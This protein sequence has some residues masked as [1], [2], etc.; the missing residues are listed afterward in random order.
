VKKNNKAAILYAF[1]LILSLTFTSKDANS[2][3][4]EPTIFIDPPS[5][6]DEANTFGN[7]TINVNISYIEGLH[8]WSVNL[9]Y[10]PELLHTNSSLIK[11]GSFLKSGGST[12]FVVSPPIEDYIAVGSSISGYGSAE[13]GSGTL[14]SVTF[15]L[16]RRG[17]T[18]LHLFRTKLT[19]VDGNPITHSSQDGCFRNIESLQIPKAIF[20]YT[21]QAYNVTVNASSSYSPSGTIQNYLWFWGGISDPEKQTSTTN[22]V[23]YHLYPEK[24][25][26]EHENATVRL[27]VTDSNDVTAN[28][29][30]AMITFGIAIHDVTILSVQASPKNVI[31]NYSTTVSV[32]VSNKGNQLENTTLTVSYNS[33]FF[34]FQNITA[35][36]W[37]TLHTDQI[38]A[39]AGLENRTITYFWNTTG[40]PLGFYA[41]KAEASPVQGEENTANNILIGS[42]RIVTVLHTPVPIFDFNPTK[43][44]ANRE[45]TFN[46]SMSYDID[47]VIISYAWNFGDSS[48]TTTT[49]PSTTHI[50][51]KAGTF[52]VTL[53]VT[54]DNIISKNTT[55]SI[56]IQKLATTTTISTA[57]TTIRVDST[58]A[59]NGKVAGAESPV[60]V[61]ILQ[62]TYGKGVW[63]TLT[64]L[65][66]DPSGIFSY[67]HS[68]H[69]AGAYQLKAECNSDDVYQAST[70]NTILITAKFNSTIAIHADKTH[71]P[72]GE[73]TALTGTINPT[74]YGAIAT[75][76]Y[77]L[78]NG[79][80]NLIAHT[81]TNENGNYMFNWRPNQAGTY[82]LRAK[83]NGTPQAFGSQSTTTTVTVTQT[84]STP[85][86]YIIY[87]AAIIALIATA[88]ILTWTRKHKTSPSP[89]NK[90]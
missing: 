86:T 7:F 81:F 21:A 17:E 2:Q 76:E 47:G 22:P 42:M 15:V 84:P 87:A 67:N 14:A 11:E 44:Y 4:P 61:T 31:G 64:H 48:T 34:D 57:A 63:T 35:T 73:T 45:V 53:T 30:V 60:N 83:W 56:T 89:T 66:T 41:I 12:F 25:P 43:P 3:P 79:S 10:N 77:K 50:Y 90:K 8:G 70:S 62:T 27:I 33:T 20:T 32:V 5:L 88:T 9:R 82:K 52:L 68:L 58:T 28:I 72:L 6:T 13:P 39:T 71:I 69:T 51:K 26:P 38:N 29:V 1:I 18:D 19:D 16:R 40:Y 23:I 36:Q 59:I 74:S 46:A 65:Q 55:Q 75:I 49:Q 37:T 54:D 78:N 80:W 85:A 24:M